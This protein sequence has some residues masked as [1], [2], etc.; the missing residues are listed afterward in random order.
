MRKKT[1]DSKKTA[2]KKWQEKK[3]MKA[4]TGILL[5]GFLAL[6]LAGCGR[7]SSKQSWTEDN[8]TDQLYS[9]TQ[10]DTEIFLFQINGRVY[11]VDGVY[12]VDRF[13]DEEMEDGGFY[14]ITADVTI[15]NGGVAGY[16]N[17]PQ[18]DQVKE[19]VPVS[20]SDLN[21]PA[22][23]EKQ[24]GLVL[25]GDYGDGDVFLRE[26]GM[27]AV[28]KDGD[29]IWQYSKET[30]RDDGTRICLRE[31]VTEETA[32][33]GISEGILSCEDYFVIP[34]PDKQVK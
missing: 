31:G 33:K 7:E 8:S 17:F 26:S 21:L 15:L 5:A 23:S 4:I 29:W 25:I 27:K 9:E 30:D 24:Y 28:W 22:V 16:Y 1:T 12:P 14:R 2:E 6:F 20:W 19:C 10:A 18:I 3:Y 32:E 13:I 11:T 34:L